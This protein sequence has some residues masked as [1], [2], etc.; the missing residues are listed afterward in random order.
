MRNAGNNHALDVGKNLLE[1]CRRFRRR[2]LELLQHSARRVGWTNPTFA[3]VLP[4]IGDP[5][6]KTT[7][8]LSKN[9]RRDIAEMIWS[10]FHSRRAELESEAETEME[11]AE[12]F[13]AMT[14]GINSVIE[15]D[16]PDRQLIAKAATNPVT[17]VAQSRIFRAW[18]QI[19]GIGKERA[20]QFAK[21]RKGVLGVKHR[22]KFAADWMA[23]AIVRAKIALGETSHGGV[24]TIEKTLVDRNL[25]RF[26]RT[27]GG[28]RMNHAN[29]RAE[30][31]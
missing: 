11:R 12:I 30:G 24:P 18:Q 13:V 5:I 31:K 3:D 29:T 7:K 28:K 26:A 17:H 14:I 23:L 4:I 9:I 22:L 16:R 1:C 21:N 15:T 2:I 20:L 27:A 10:I 25:S 8:L 6:G 19:A